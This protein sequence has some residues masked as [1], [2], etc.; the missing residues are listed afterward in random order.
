VFG[1]PAR[2]WIST[3]NELAVISCTTNPPEVAA[4]LALLQSPTAGPF[5]RA[6]TCSH[7]PGRYSWSVGAEP[8]RS[9]TLASSSR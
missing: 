9:W 8:A 6:F 7:R 5:A 1:A 3:R 4:A 2:S